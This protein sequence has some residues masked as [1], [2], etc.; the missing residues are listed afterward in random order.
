MHGWWQH[1]IVDSG[2]WPRMRCFVA[3]VVT[4]LTTRLISTGRAVRPTD[5]RCAAGTRARSA[6]PGARAS[7]AGGGGPAPPPPPAAFVST[8]IG[9]P[10]IAGA[11]FASD[12]PDALERG[13]LAGDTR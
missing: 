10:G 1:E 8:T 2:K 13:E 4:F 12:E 11:R 9:E 3:F 6:R 5:A 7:R